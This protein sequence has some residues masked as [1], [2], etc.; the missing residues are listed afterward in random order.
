MINHLNPKSL[1]F[2][3]IA[4][5][6]VLLLFNRVTAYGNANLKAPAQIDG[7][8]L[9]VAQ[10]LPPCLRATPLVL[11]LEQ[12]GTYIAGLLTA[13]NNKA[14]ATS[15]EKP[16]LTGRF[17]EMGNLTLIGSAQDELCL[18]Q[19]G[20]VKIIG[21]ISHSRF[22][23]QIQVGAGTQWSQFTAQRQAVAKQDKEVH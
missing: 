23:G 22:N 21:T 20:Q 12:S 8:Y 6:S 18:A 4:I 14:I 16:G 15:E 3:G 10:E 19:G 1:A 17:G 9:L 5:G 13:G 7:R 2:Y 11:T